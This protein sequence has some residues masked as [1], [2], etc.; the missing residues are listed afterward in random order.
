MPF[1]EFLAKYNDGVPPRE[2]AHLMASQESACGIEQ[3][4]NEK[5]RCFAPSPSFVLAAND[6]FQF[7]CVDW[8]PRVVPIKA[9][10]DF[11][12]LVPYRYVAPMIKP[13]YQ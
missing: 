2:L 1:S 3:T 11:I 7:R 13:I 4:L 10:N 6:L 8:F 12:F 5:W 9:P